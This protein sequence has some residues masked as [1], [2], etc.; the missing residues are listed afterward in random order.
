MDFLSVLNVV[1][2]EFDARIAALS[3]VAISITTSTK[4]KSKDFEC[5]NFTKRVNKK[6]RKALWFHEPEHVELAIK[7]RDA[8][9]TFE[10]CRDMNGIGGCVEKTLKQIIGE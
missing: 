3:V 7:I 10:C 6:I 9:T 1:T 8:W 2:D 5:G 4:I